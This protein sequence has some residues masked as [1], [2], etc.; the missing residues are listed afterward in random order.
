VRGGHEGRV[1]R[2]EA[3]VDLEGVCAKQALRIVAEEGY[4]LLCLVSR[5]RP[6]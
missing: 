1:G 3:H 6:L 2:Y 5:Q 4:G